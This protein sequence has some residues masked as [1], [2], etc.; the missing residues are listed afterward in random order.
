MTTLSG[1]QFGPANGGPPQKLIFLCH[2]VGADGN[3]LIGLAPMLAT[4]FP[5]A[6]FLAPD[7]PEPCDRSPFGRQWFSLGDLDPHKLGAGVRGA[8]RI[9]DAYIEETCAKHGVTAFALAG[10]SQGA[11]TVLFTGLRR[12]A[13]PRAILAYSGALIEPQTLAAEARNRSPVLLVHGLD[14]TVVPA[15]RS[16]DAQAALQAAGIPVHGIFTP[17]L[18]HAIDPAGIAAGAAVLAHAFA[19]QPCF[20]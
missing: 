4:S 9:L 10:F 8:A 19:G 6:L 5:D 7:A 18:G 2:G 17:G 12:T 14:D 3:D 1:P 11:M 15:F 16:R 20:P 13:A